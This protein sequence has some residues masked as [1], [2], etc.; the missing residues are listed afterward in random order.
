M[1][2]FRTAW[3]L[4]SVWLFF[5]FV[6]VSAIALP[7]LVDRTLAPNA[8]NEGI[9]LSLEQQVGAGRRADSVPGSSLYFITRDPDS[10]IA[11]LGNY[12]GQLKGRLRLG[13]NPSVE[14]RAGIY[15]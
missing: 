6:L 1:S 12:R 11:N 15:P 3:S 9:A 7:Q 13:M 14:Q 8:A 5:T 2:R 4:R 10:G